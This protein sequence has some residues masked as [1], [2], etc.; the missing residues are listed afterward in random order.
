MLNDRFVIHFF[1][2][3]NN[4][5]IVQGKEYLAVVILFLRITYLVSFLVC[6][7]RIKILPTIKSITN[8]DQKNMT[9]NFIRPHKHKSFA[10]HAEKS[11][12]L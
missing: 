1:M 10:K 8:L 11:H 3:V 2:V 4:I 6:S 12:M 7:S 9:V 5:V